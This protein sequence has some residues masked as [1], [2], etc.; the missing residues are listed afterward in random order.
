MTANPCLTILPYSEDP[1]RQLAQRV[2]EQ[3]R[4]Q[5][6]NLTDCIVMLPTPQAGQRLRSLL[7]E[8]AEAKG[9]SA[10][11]GPTID[12]LP[13]WISQQSAN[14]RP[15]LSEQQRELM[16]VEAL[17]TH[18]FLYGAGN[19]WTLADSLL[20]L[21]DDLGAAHISLPDSLDDFLDTVSNAY[22]AQNNDSLFGEAKLVHTLWQAWHQQMQENGVIDRHSDYILKLAANQKSL[23][24]KF[25]FYIA[26]LSSLSSAEAQWLQPLLQQQRVF[27]VLQAS[28]AIADTDYHPDVITQNLLQKLNLSVDNPDS[29]SAFTHCLN[30]IFSNQETPLQVR[31]TQLAE[32]IPQSPVSELLSVFEASSAE[33]EAQAIDAQVRLWWHEGKRNIGIVTQNRRLARRVRALLERSG[34]ELQDAAGWALSTTSAAAT[35]ERWL[36]TVEEDFAHQPLLDFLKSPFLLPQRERE[37]LLSCVYR[38]EQGVV[39]K[40]N[41]ARGMDRYREHLQYRQNRL[42]AELT[43]DYDDIHL[44]LDVIEAA[45][46]PLRAL[47]SNK[48]GNGIGNGIG[49]KKYTPQDFLQALDK[50]LA[51]L[52]L[53][54]SLAEDAAGQRILEE[55]RA[56]QTASDGSNL[57]MQWNEFRAWL[58]RT[59]ERFNFQPPSQSSQ[60]QLMSLSQS[61]LSRF[62]ALIIAGAEAEYLPGSAGGSPF[63]NDGVRQALGLPSHTQALS[64]KFHQFRC[65]LESADSVLVTCRSEQDGD[66]VVASPWL[67]RLQSFHHIAYG[68]RLINTTLSELVN[69]QDTLLT[70]VVTPLPQPVPAN[71]AASIAATLFPEQ[72]SA[73]AY[74]QLIN[75]PYQFFAA[76]CLQLEAPEGIREMLQKADYGERVHLCLQA[77]HEDVQDLPGPFAANISEENK[78]TAMQCLNDIATAV[79][80]RD[81]E[82]NFLHRGWL[83]R[84]QA[85]IP[86]YINWQLARQVQWRM[87]AAELNISREHNTVVLRGRLDRVDTGT[88]ADSGAPIV[89]I[90]DYKTGAIPKEADVLSGES[91]QLPFY[92]L[93]AAQINH[94]TVDRVEYLDLDNTKDAKKGGAAPAV[95]SVGVLEKEALDTLNTENAE[96]LDLLVNQILAGAPLPAWGDEKTCA[97]CQMSGLCR[98]DAW[99]NTESGAE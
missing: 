41:I 99:E 72:L 16:L 67:E 94:G 62:D 78:A 18:K 36:E 86:G 32:Q 61:S 64:E 24:D 65:L 98:R 20:E 82:D 5:L 92:A 46:A 2:I 26:G 52:G 96:R 10:L 53:N 38:F 57:R 8:L 6:P 68:D 69:Q 93:L 45:A 19:P 14:Q 21:F 37:E 39:L 29:N 7:L 43:G 83:K 75:C 79:F 84:W 87:Q 51:Q 91:V 9:H 25:H 56:M 77:F 33:K 95:R 81:L 31:A 71:P 1:L 12:T 40:E 80:A 11:L 50:S 90:V 4:N 89:S 49:N 54:I 73:S 28:S 76:R 42:P 55:L 35:V 70:H 27:L 17:I 60:V 59:L 22:G 15:V 85:M 63:F 3:H 34:I 66:E 48:I 30:Q 47:I 97:Y 23:S 58:G 44:L 13:R 74:Q 88:D